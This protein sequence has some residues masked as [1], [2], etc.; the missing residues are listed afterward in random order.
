MLLCGHLILYCGLVTDHTDYFSTVCTYL[1]YMY[2]SKSPYVYHVLRW[3]FASALIA[4][5]LHVLLQCTCW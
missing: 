2:V 1:D 4:V 3:F 5:L